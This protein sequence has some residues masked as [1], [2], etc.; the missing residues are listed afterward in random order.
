MK[1]IKTLSILLFSCGFLF[2]NCIQKEAVVVKSYSTITDTDLESAV[3]YEA[4]IRQ[5]SEQGDFSSFT[6]DIPS[7]KELGV[8]IIWLMP[9]HAISIEKRKAK[10]DVNVS[11]IE[12]PE[13]RKKYLGSY[14]SVSDY[15]SINPEFGDAND[16]EELI[17]VAHNNGMYVIL[18][19]VPNHTGWD[20]PWITEHPDY[21]TQDSL[22]NIIDPIDPGTGASWGWT[23]VADLNFDN[24][25]LWEAM[26]DEMK[27]WIT[28]FDIDGYRC[29]VAHGVPVEFWEYAVPKLR[30]EKDIFMLAEAES[31][32]L[33][34]NAFEMDYNWEGHH[35]MNDI[36]KGNKSVSDWDQYMIRCSTN[37][38]ADD[39]RMN[40]VTNHD[41]NSWAG[42]VKERMGDASELM[43]A[44]S[45]LQPG[46]PLIYSGQEYDM[47]HKLLFFE[48]D[49][50]PKTK[51]STWNT[52]VKLGKLKTDN[53][54]LNGGKNP[55]SYNRLDAYGSEHIMVFSRQ[56][57]E[58]TV[59]FI[60]NMSADP[61]EF[62]FP[63]EGR[64]TN[65]M[66]GEP[67]DYNL[68]GT[69]NFAA[70]EYKILI[71]K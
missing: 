31:S 49:Q 55:A 69:Y 62:N 60:G 15:R 21:Y 64:F 53:P 63:I 42:P 35:I 65:W 24:K 20:H 54:A 46:M 52:L 38:E 48:K 8:K 50:I 71:P 61:A 43:L 40:F 18:D 51:G 2:I 59:Y 25:E 44:F 37:Y 11:D 17:K 4:N 41:E 39:I 5:Y 36:S 10:S 34:K 1:Q 9:I 47:D 12:D 23:D 66:N 16:F 32:T 29:D 7:L 68:G 28:D 33:L 70:W 27:Y 3:I 6:K 58:S 13:E 30:K 26:I 19:W 56:K 45:Y 22:G 67:E 57:G 14:Y